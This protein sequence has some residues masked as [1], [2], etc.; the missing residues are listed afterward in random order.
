MENFRYV[1]LFFLLMLSFYGC[2][3]GG[4]CSNIF[5][6]GGGGFPVTVEKVRVKEI[7]PTTTVIG[8]LVANDKSD[9]NLPFDAKIQ[10]VYVN[11]GSSV[12]AGDPLFKLMEE[13]IT[14]ELNVAK[15]RKTELESV[16]E[17]NTTLLRSKEK[18]LEDG[19]IN[20][21]ELTRLEKQVRTDE[22]ELERIKAEITKL[23]GS[24]ERVLITSP[25]AGIV[26]RREISSGSVVKAG[27]S[28]VEITN[29][30][31]I[32]AAF[33]LEGIQSDAVTLN[34]PLKISIAELPDKNVTGKISFINPELSLQGKTFTVWASIP[35][36]E[37]LLKA[38]MTAS[39]DFTSNNIRYTFLIPESSLL[40]KSSGPYVFKV[41]KGAAK[42]TPVTIISKEG[43]Q[44]EVI[45]GLDKEDIVVV[46][47]AEALFDGA[48]V[49]IW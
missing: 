33:D 28:L 10:E 13:D 22:A 19:K 39:A 5:H 49:N 1:F 34:M 36:D 43:D 7:S 6:S 45:T 21:D 30:N 24:L 41:T 23:N 16:I 15:A 2:G 20:Q 4:G 42:K 8:K 26:T 12:R 47:G 35:N 40:S 14:N 27:S 44:V 29:G 32:N 46:K 38:G 37:G 48:E 9:I 25:I 3:G 18:A 11:I 31:P 17:D